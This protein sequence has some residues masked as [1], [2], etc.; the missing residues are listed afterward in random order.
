MG[1]YNFLPMVRG[2]GTKTKCGVKHKEE[3]AFELPEE[4]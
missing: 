2:F 3:G 4:E 1:E